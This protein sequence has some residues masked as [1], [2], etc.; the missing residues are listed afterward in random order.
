[1]ILFRGL[2]DQ[3]LFLQPL[4]A[5]V[6]AMVGFREMAYREGRAAVA[7][8]EVPR[9]E[10]LELPVKVEQEVW[11]VLVAVLVAVVELVL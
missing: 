9:L 11:G 6:E 10:G 4:Q 5:L 2:L 8:A 7:A 1:M 3:I